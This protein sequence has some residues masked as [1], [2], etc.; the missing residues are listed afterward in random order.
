MFTLGSFE[1]PANQERALGGLAGLAQRYGLTVIV[2]GAIVYGSLYPF[3][4]HDTGSFGADISHLAGT[5]KQPP[6]SRG[7]LLAN[8]LLYMP[9]GLAIALALAPH[10]PNF[11]VLV[12]AGI[13]G[14]ILSLAI[15][16][17]Q[18]FEASRV[19][20][21][22][23]FYLNVAG[24]F[25]GAALARTSGIGWSA[26]SWPRGSAAAFARLLLLAWLGWRLYPYVPTIDLHKYWQSVKPL[27]APHITP[28]EI[29]RY[30]VY[31]WSAIFLFQTGLG[32]KRMPLVLPAVLC[33]F[34]AKIVIIGLVITPSEL[35]GAGLAVFLG[36]PILKR[37]AALGVACLA[38]LLL[39]TII[40]SRVLPWQFSEVQKAFQWIPFYSVLHGSLQVNAISF[41]EKFYLYGAA[42]LLLVT[43]GMRLTIAVALECA[44][45]FAT[46]LLQTF[47]VERSA[48]I[49]DVI[50]AM[51]AGVIY[52][53]LRRRPAEKN[54]G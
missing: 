10:R 30:A 53:F 4:F 22:S 11:R 34:A 29:L 48:E 46:S 14:A 27:L 23:D 12:L 6:Q 32:A 44:I 50:L 47:M 45:L 19:S 26:A 40:L 49:T 3:V 52:M 43:A 8:I 25:A 35:L 31:W 18:F 36:Q 17:S 41:A 2:A 39:L 13:G 20:V 42:L 24:T 28:Y 16:L 38:V 15:E 54:A 51:L 5:W 7:D 33:F 1:P 21:L 37:H 9:L